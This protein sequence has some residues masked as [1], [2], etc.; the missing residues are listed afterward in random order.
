MADKKKV[1]L[2][3]QEMSPYTEGTE[4]ADVVFQ[5]AKTL[6]ESGADVRIL[7][8]R[9]GCVNERR[10]RLHEVVRL[11]G[12]NIMVDDDDCPLIIKVASLPGTRLQVYFLDNDEFFKHYEQF[13]DDKGLV[14][15]SSMD[16]MIFF[17]KS[18]IETVKKFGWSPDV[19]H[20]HGWLAA[21][22]PAYL[23]T[24]NRNEPVFQSAKLV[25][26]LYGAAVCNN[27]FGA[28]WT[29]KAAE[30]Q[31]QDATGFEQDGTWDLMR[32][33]AHYADGL[34]LHLPDGSTPELPAS[35]VVAQGSELETSHY[36]GFY[37][38]LMQPTTV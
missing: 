21:L 29:K 8:P 19:V 27:E 26:S 13:R 3:A 5:T 10:H 33:I 32:G 12:M 38:E 1:L 30:N 20:C 14:N 9:L 34:I 37:S 18:I 15:A 4:M 11:S 6:Q 7:M 23:R 2:I 16:R 22:L 28:Q 25:S 36:L 17:A 24:S 35:L 31:L